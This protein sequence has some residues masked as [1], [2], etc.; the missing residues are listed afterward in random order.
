MKSIEDLHKH[1]IKTVWLAE[2]VGISEALLRYHF[3]TGFPDE[4]I[5][6]R[7]AMALQKHCEDVLRDS[8]R[9]TPK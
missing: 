1:G 8:K 7:V 2:R 3:K 9:L 5:K 4:R 6:S